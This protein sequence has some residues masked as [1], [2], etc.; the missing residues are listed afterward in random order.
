LFEAYSDIL[1]L[2]EFCEAAR[3]RKNQAYSLIKSDKVNAYKA[4]KNWRIPRKAIEDYVI[5]QYKKS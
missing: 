1:T 3:I 5:Q 2:E 4:G